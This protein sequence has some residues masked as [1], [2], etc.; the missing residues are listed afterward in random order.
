MDNYTIEEHDKVKRITTTLKDYYSMPTHYQYVRKYKFSFLWEM[1]E[2]A[3]SV[4]NHKVTKSRGA[5]YVS[6]VK[7]YGNSPDTWN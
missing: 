2:L 3:M 6:N 4:P 1:V 7:R 5:I